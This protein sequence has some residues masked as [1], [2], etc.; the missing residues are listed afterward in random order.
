MRLSA[1]LIFLVISFSSFAQNKIL[2]HDDFDKWKTIKESKLSPNGEF[3]VYEVAPGKGDGTLHIASKS[4]KELIQIPRGEKSSITWD[5]KFV[6]F[7]IKPQYESII[8]LRR[9]K[10]DDDKLPKDSLGIY[11]VA[12]NK[13]EKIARVKGYVI[14]KESENLLTYTLEEPLPEKVEKDTTEADSIKQEKPKSAKSVNKENGYHIVIRN[15]ANANQDTIFYATDYKLAKRSDKLI[16]HTSGKDSTVKEGIYYYNP[17]S[18]EHKPL[19]RSKGKFKQLTLS[20]DGLQAAFLSDLDTTK[21][22]I[23]DYQ[24]RYWNAGKDSAV[25]IAHQSTR[26]IPEKWL[27]NKNGKVHFSQSGSRLF[28][29][30]YP[31]PLVQDTT[32][33]P[34]EII[35]V[36]IWNYQNGRLHTQQNI[37]ADDDKKKA[38][39]AYFDTLDE[40]VIQ[41]ENLQVP[42]IRL[43]NHGDSE[44]A[45]GIS[46]LPYQKYIS[47]EGFPMRNDY[48]SVN[49]KTGKATLAIEDLRG[50]GDIS[51]DGNYLYWYNAEDT[52]WYSYDNDSKNTY[53]LTKSIVTSLADEENDQPNYPF[54]YGTAGWTE[55]D[56]HF[57]VYDRFDIWKLDPTNKIA[58]VNITN[59]RTS[60]T[61]YRVQDLDKE[62][63]ALNA[64]VMILHT[65][66]EGNKNEGYA[67]MK[68]FGAPKQ[69]IDEPARFTLLNKAEKANTITFQKG[70][71]NSYYDIS[72]TDLSLKKVVKISEVNPQQAAYAWGTVE[73]VSWTSLDGIPLTGKLYKPANF[74]PNK[75]YPMIVNFYETHSDDLHRHWGVFPSRSTVNAAFYSNRGYLVFNPDV[76]YK[77]GYPGESAYNCVVSGTTALIEKGFVDKDKIGLQGHSW[78]GYQIAYLITKTDLF[79]CA[80]AGAVVSNMISAYG[81]IR[82]WTGLSRMFQYEHTQSRIGGTLWEYPNRYI[83]NSP[84]FYA[85]KVNTPLLMMH[86]DADG[87]VPWYQG[88]EYYVSLRRL[89]KPV[90]M[91]NYNGEPHWPT[92][93][94]NIRD[95]NIRM[96]QFFDHY[97]KDAPMPEWMKK[98]VPAVEKGIN[99]GLGLVKE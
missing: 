24:L 63:A 67:L 32:L 91:L 1:F 3:I 7:Q 6:I 21:A 95:F 5:S 77:E 74:D 50:S 48:Y 40:N 39:S 51:A 18:Q 99:K 52:T 62:E 43:T 54:Q 87:H 35:H 36:E 71:H 70:N 37:E 86:N 64:D 65:F 23:R 73:L 97:L 57:L 72:A 22:L 26:G 2:L 10:T 68:N 84:I 93:W 89:G 46:N 4:G 45:I 8:A 33:L 80:E 76:V 34:E 92:K 14:P 66:K 98:G 83:E 78:G 42:E 31:E 28:F 19:T 27:V 17:A 82:W 69:M 88:I 53:A 15:L 20:E 94:E 29:G 55:G 96:N 85:D 12:N 79:A 9:K 44:Y 49:T 16:Y 47:W 30:T 75:K 81:G 25:V 58:P 90:W 13:L 11:N 61:Q 56:Q 59:G 41:L 38:Y 60:Q